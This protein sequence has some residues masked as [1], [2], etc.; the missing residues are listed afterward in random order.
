MNDSY[1]PLFKIKPASWG[2]MGALTIVSLISFPLDIT[3]GVLV[4]GILV[5]VNLHFFHRVLTKAL[6]PGT[7]VTP[8]SVLLNYYLLFLATVLIIFIMISQHWLNGLGL[9]LGLSTF[10]ITILAVLIQQMS[11]VLFRK[12]IKEAG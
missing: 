4:G 6:K 11:L 1:R 9:I 8:R 10:I 12:I 5:V 7:K 2:V 3:L